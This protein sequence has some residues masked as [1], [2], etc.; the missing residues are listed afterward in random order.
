MINKDLIKMHEDNFVNSEF[1]KELLE[2]TKA[3]TISRE[4]DVQKARSR[5]ADQKDVDKE[6]KRSDRKSESQAEASNPWKSV[7]IVKT[8]QDNKTR[9]IPKSDFDSNKHE[10]LYGEAPGQ[11][12]KPEVTPNVAQE[13]S[14]QDDFEASKTSNRLLGVQRKTKKR[15]KE[16]VKSD[17]FEYPKNGVEKQ[18]PNSSYADWDHSPDSLVKGLATISSVS[19]GRSVDV[20]IAKRMFG[21]SQTLGDSSIR[22]Y[23]QIAQNIKGNFFI[24]EPEQSYPTSDEFKDLVGEMDIPTTDLLIQ[25]EN[26]TMYKSAII[27]NKKKILTNP[28]SDL[29]FNFA[30][31]TTIADQNEKLN[32]NIDELK[33]KIINFISGFNLNSV[34]MKSDKSRIMNYK[35]EIISE[36][37]KILTSNE[38]F[39]RFVVIETLT[40]MNKFGVE[41]PASANTL[42][43]MS[44]DGTNLRI[45]PLTEENVV[46]L[47]NETE[48]KLRLKSKPEGS[49]FDQVVELLQQTRGS[50]DNTPQITEF[51]DLTED[52]SDAKILYDQIMLQYSDMSKV[53]SLFYLLNIECQSIVISNVDLDVISSIPSGD[54]NKIK[55]NNIHHHIEVENDVNF[56]DGS[57]FQ[58][59]ERDYKF[60]YNSYHKKKAQKKRR[61]G[62]NAARRKSEREGKVER[63]DGKDIDHKDHN[64]LNNSSSN[65]RVRDRSK[66]RGDNK[67]PV[68][69]DHGAGFEGTDEL[70]LKYVRDT[71]YMKIPMNLLSRRNHG[72]IQRKKDESDK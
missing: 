26:G 22:A 2:F 4:R 36:F 7:I 50:R 61:A 44:R 17:R 12:P 42:I 64:P 70:L 10:L 23:Q 47:V 18:D 15:K 6:R 65:L 33:V 29:I 46:K 62:R 13:I 72:R 37:E 1:N 53:E 56:Y 32:K 34:T 43:S 3:N 38:L 40:G 59:E 27:E 45:C 11:P 30:I 39:E 60:E 52:S 24:V 35:E 58:I 21:M 51:F 31:N 67:V 8:N 20:G 55:V 66:N 28:D 69:E 68:K 57:D 41:S 5:G 19:N 49:P 14:Q 54:F 48:I 9:L 16:V 71:P 63:G 25:D